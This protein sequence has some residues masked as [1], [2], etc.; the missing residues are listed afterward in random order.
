MDF[1]FENQSS[2]LDGR[3][4]SIESSFQRFHTFLILYVK[5]TRSKK[6]SC[7]QPQ[8]NVIICY[9]QFVI[10]IVCIVIGH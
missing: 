4:C 7:Y 3:A 8:K 1:Y 10:M 9:I 2:F 5:V 6:M